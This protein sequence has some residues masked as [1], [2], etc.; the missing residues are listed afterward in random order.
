VR[1]LN[2]SRDCLHLEIDA[3]LSKRVSA[4]TADILSTSGMRKADYRTHCQ[5]AKIG[6][7]DCA[8]LDDTTLAELDHGPS[9]YIDVEE[10]ELCERRAGN[11]S[12]G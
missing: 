4:R 2:G 9:P 3:I 8:W 1:L 12:R 5:D 10:L 11:T 7:Q 6:S